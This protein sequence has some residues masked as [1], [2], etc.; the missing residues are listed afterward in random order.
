[1]NAER[2]TKEEFEDYERV[3]KSGETN[4]IDFETVSELSDNLSEDKVKTIVKNH[5]KLKENFKGE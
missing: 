5:D 3:R 4:M 1:M 2:I